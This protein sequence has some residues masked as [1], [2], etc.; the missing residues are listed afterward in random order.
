MDLANDLLNALKV[1]CF[2]SVSLSCVFA[3]ARSVQRAVGV[4][5]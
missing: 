4:S 1:L 2:T 5:G 3:W